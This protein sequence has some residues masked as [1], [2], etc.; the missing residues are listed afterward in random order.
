MRAPVIV[1]GKQAV[2]KSACITCTGDDPLVI[3]ACVNDL[4]YYRAVSKTN[5]VIY[6]NDIWRICVQKFKVL[7]L[8][9]FFT[10]STFVSRPKYTAW[11]HGKELDVLRERFSRL[12]ITRREALL[13]VSLHW[14]FLP[15]WQL[16]TQCLPTA[17]PP[18]TNGFIRTPIENTSLKATGQKSKITQQRLLVWKTLRKKTHYWPS[19]TLPR[20]WAFHRGAFPIR[21]NTSEVT[22]RFVCAEGFTF[23]RQTS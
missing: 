19:K 10:T 11:N 16:L 17:V 21:L 4:L 3:R 13:S 2:R 7:S 1:G 8:T 15:P 22:E 6:W 12:H 5:G 14:A 20:S 18:S 9:V 23:S